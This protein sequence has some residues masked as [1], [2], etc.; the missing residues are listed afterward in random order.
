MP[1]LLPALL[2]TTPIR[3]AQPPDPLD[4]P[5]LH[6]LPPAALADLPRPRKPS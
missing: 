3:R 6:D 5:A 2:R 4:H 1:Y